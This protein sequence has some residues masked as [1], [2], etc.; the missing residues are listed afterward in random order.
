MG[1]YGDSPKYPGEYDIHVHASG[2]LNLKMPCG[3]IRTTEEKL[4]RTTSGEK[5]KL[6]R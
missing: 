3:T 2:E 5:F 4:G 6:Q 1:K